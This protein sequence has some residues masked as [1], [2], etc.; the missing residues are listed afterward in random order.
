MLILHIG[1]PKTATS[2]LQNAFFPRHPGIYFLGK[3]VDGQR[4]WTGW[5]TPE[6]HSLMGRLERTNLDF[7]P[8]PCEIA[9]LVERVQAEAGQRPVVISSEDLC[10]FSG[11]D[12]F[13]K[14]ER[15]RHLLALLG[16][17][18]LVLAVRDQVSLLR[19]LYLTEHR[20]EMLKLPGTQ[21]NWYPSFDQYLDIHFRYAWGAVLESY[22]FA[23]TTA[24]YESMVGGENLLIYAFEDFRKN[25]VGTLR[26]LCRFIGVDDADPSLGQA[27][28]TRENEHYS[29]RTY[30]FN[31]RYGRV[32]GANM[33]RAL[34][35]AAVKRRLRD[36]IKG[37]RRFDIELSADAV[38][39]IVNYYRADNEAL[40]EKYGIRL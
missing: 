19:S 28:A 29:A 9:K 15:I 10:S 21:Q 38:A 14:I 35:P 36:W 20:G 33:V 26:Q 27:A 37:G 13:T 16:P 32:A 11:T 25:T 8:E 22:R 12:S 31:G 30:A 4:G 7:R 39:R 40:L 34:M 23:A 17:I 24:R 1:A 6:I 3:E 2:T 5:R 18:R